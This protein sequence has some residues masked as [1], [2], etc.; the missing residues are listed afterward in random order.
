M[1]EDDEFGGLEAVLAASL[2]EFGL[3]AQAG[4]TGLLR[5]MQGNR[6]MTEAILNQHI[7][8]LQERVATHALAVQSLLKTSS[9]DVAR[10]LG[11][12]NEEAH[13]EGDQLAEEFFDSKIQPDLMAAGLTAD[14]IARQ[15][16]VFCLMVVSARA[17]MQGYSRGPYVTKTGKVLTDDD[18]EKLA[19]EAEREL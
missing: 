17:E 6:A 3:P 18:V 19:D 2:E 12:S 7:D 11:T 15:R 9:V 1:T 16:G 10:S 13:V 8:M 14:A 5:H 4:L